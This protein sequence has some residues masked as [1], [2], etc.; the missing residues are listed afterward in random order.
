MNTEIKKKENGTPGYIWFPWV[1]I[2]TK[3][4]ISDKNGT[5]CYWQIGYWMR[6]KLFIHRL[7]HKTKKLY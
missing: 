1:I 5:Q 6:F 4:C 2:T 7:F 3:A